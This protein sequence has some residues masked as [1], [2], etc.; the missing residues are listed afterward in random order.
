[1]ASS[2]CG[3][4]KQKMNGFNNHNQTDEKQH[5]HTNGHSKTNG[6]LT[7][8]HSNGHLYTEQVAVPEMC[9]Y[10]FEVLNAELNN[11]EPPATPLFTND[12]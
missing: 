3:T 9:F 1:M 4:K 2:C 5:A 8:G 12:A 6:H 7:N 11:A 10:C